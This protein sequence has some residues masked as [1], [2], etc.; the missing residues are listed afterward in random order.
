MSYGVNRIGQRA[1]SFQV[2]GIK[3]EQRGD[4]TYV[5]EAGRLVKEVEYYTVT[6]PECGIPTY[7]EDTYEKICPECGMVCSADDEKVV[8]PQDDY[9]SAR[10]NGGPSGIPALND[11][12]PGTSSSNSTFV[13]KRTLV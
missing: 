3:S 12:A 10:C 9:D 8:L 7:I 2:V 5:M 1:D 11:P 4:G 13:K 6:C